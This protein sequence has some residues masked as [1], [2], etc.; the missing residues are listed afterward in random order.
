VAAPAAN[1]GAILPVLS[2][3]SCQ[4]GALT[5]TPL[6][7]PVAG[8]D[9]YGIKL[10]DCTGNWQPPA[11]AGVGVAAVAAAPARVSLGRPR[12]GPNGRL[13]VPVYV[14]SAR[15]FLALELEVTH[16]PLALRVAGV[17]SL[18]AARGSVMRYRSDD[19]G[20]TKIALASAVPIGAGASAVL[21][22]EFEPVDG[23]AADSVELRGAVVDNGPAVTQ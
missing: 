7:P 20:Q 15:P 3:T 22:L 8:Q 18:P 10:G 11:G 4:N 14:R 16:D 1:H 13:R 12:P 9:F 6:V 19:G 23:T 21:T 2:G 17:R 5:F